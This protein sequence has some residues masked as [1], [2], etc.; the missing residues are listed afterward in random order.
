MS[1]RS[2]T[3]N[4]MRYLIALLGPEEAARLTRPLTADEEQ[5]VDEAL[6]RYDGDRIAALG[7]DDLPADVRAEIRRVMA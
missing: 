3:L 7:A 6:A 5:L 1:H 4:H 2:E